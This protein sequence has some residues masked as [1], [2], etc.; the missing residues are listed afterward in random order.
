MGC[1]Y[2]KGTPTS[3]EL[4]LDLSK[5]SPTKTSNAQLDTKPAEDDFDDISLN[6]GLSHN[7]HANIDQ[8]SPRAMADIGLAFLNVQPLV[9]SVGT[10]Y[11]NDRVSS[12]VFMS[13]ASLS[14]S[15]TPP[16]CGRPRAVTLFSKQ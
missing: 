8:M 14:G 5:S 1:C 13:I 11:I 12:A 7:R 15:F 2:A 9:L 6:S 3:P 10:P 16:P 4:T